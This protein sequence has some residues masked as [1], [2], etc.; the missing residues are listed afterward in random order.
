[1][2]GNLGR[3]EVMSP[4]NRTKRNNAEEG[5]DRSSPISSVNG[6]FLGDFNGYIFGEYAKYC[7]RRP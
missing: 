4:S 5:A 2:R 3:A 6:D 1:M 7:G